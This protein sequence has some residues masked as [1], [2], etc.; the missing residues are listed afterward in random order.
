M[1][2][3]S[4]IIKFEWDKANLDKSYQKHGITPKEA[5][6]VFLDEESF[7]I[8]DVKHSQKE[9]R[10]IILG[11][12]FEEKRLFIVFT[13]RD[14]KIRIISSR[15]IHKKEVKKYEKAKKNTKI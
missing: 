4:G 2:V 5:E 3:K 9:P 1:V 13:I 7:V 11:K 6:E 8:P 12:T 15:Q 14:K 10:Y